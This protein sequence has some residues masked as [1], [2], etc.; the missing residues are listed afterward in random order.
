MVFDCNGST[1]AA[2]HFFDWRACC[3]Q[4]VRAPSRAFSFGSGGRRGPTI[5]KEQ[6]R[7]HLRCG[8]RGVY[9]PSTTSARTRARFI[10]LLVR[11]R[12][13]HVHLKRPQGSVAKEGREEAACICVSAQ[14]DR[15]RACKSPPGNGAPIMPRSRAGLFRF[16]SRPN[17]NGRGDQSCALRRNLSATHHSH[18][19]AYIELTKG[20]KPQTLVCI[21]G[22]KGKVLLTLFTDQ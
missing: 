5:L 20:T 19:Q 2:L 4:P 15:Q 11:R 9:R 7:G 16:G 22:E 1:Q 12:T 3:L 6:P 18:A 21:I 8:A 13:S 14:D 10:E 17:I